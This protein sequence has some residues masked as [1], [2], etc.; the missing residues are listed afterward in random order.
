MK[1]ELVLYVKCS[2]LG[3]SDTRDACIWSK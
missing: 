3:Y 1:L 2:F